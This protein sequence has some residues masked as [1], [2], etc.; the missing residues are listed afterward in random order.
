MFVWLP[1]LFAAAPVDYAKDVAPI[2]TAKC[3]GCHQGWNVQ[4]QY[5]M[6]TVESIVK[7]GKRGVAVVPGKPDESNLYLM[8]AH[9]KK[10]VMPPASEG[11]DLTD[12]ERATL[13]AWI[14]QGAKGPAAAEAKALRKVALVLPAATVKPIR[15][16]AVHPKEPLVA[17]A[18]ANAIYLVDAKTG[19]IAGMFQ[20]PTI[21][22]VA[23]RAAPAHVSLVES[24]AFSPDGQTLASGS[25]REVTLWATAARTV[26]TRLT[27][28]ADKVTAI[29]WSPNGFATAGGAPTEDGELRVYDSTGALRKELKSPHT[30]TVFGLAFSA[31]GSRLASG[32]ADKYVKLFDTATGE[33]LKSF[34]GHTQHVLDVI[35]SPDGKRIASAGADDLIKIWDTDKG[36][37]VRDL[38]NHKLQVTRLAMVGSGPSFLAV[39]G[40]GVARRWNL[41]TGDPSRT[42]DGPKD[43]LYGVAASADGAFVATGGEAGTL[44]LYDGKSGQVLKTL[45]FSK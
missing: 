32:G 2:F 43:H 30:D 15:A 38:R 8:A 12:A 3:L 21:E 29:A 44:R 7:G 14:E 25:F 6:G 41:E 35:I 33:L 24:L 23:G 34:E 40:D 16:V 5:Q 37:R 31:D 27:G 39:S 42:F 22:A 9:R 28:F 26:K 11:N 1:L 4:G 18:R 13:K 36:E 45:T 20:D 19:A 17:V 10:P